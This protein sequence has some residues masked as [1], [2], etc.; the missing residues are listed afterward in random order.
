M[1][2]SWKAA[3]VVPLLLALGACSTPEEAPQDGPP[4]VDARFSGQQLAFGSCD[5]YATTEADKKLFASNDAY[6]CARM[7]VPLDYENPDGATAEIAMLRV[8]ARGESLGPL[9]LNSGGP[10]GTGMNFA[11][12]TATALAASPVTERFDLIGFDPRGVGASTP[13][14]NCFTDEQIATGALNNEFIVTDG[15]ATEAQTRELAE[16]CTQRSGGEQVLAAVGSRDTARDMDVLRAVLGQEKLNFLGQS[17]GTRIGALYAEQFPQHV[18]ALVLDGAV[19]PQLGFA[20]RRL[21]T[22]TAFQATFDAM[23]ADCAT[24][25]GCPLGTDPAGATEAYQKLTRPLVAEPLPVKDGGKLTYNTVVGL[26]TSLLYEPAAWPAITTAM[27][28]LRDGDGNKWIE[29]AEKL[30]STGGT[31]NFEDAI[32]AITC[33]DEERLT[34]ERAVE[35]RQDMR[36]AAPFMDPG[37]SPEGARDSCESWPVEPDPAHPYPAKVEGLPATLTI[38]ITGDTTTPHSGGE[39]LAKTLGGT[40]LTVDGYGHTIAA[41]GQNAC[42]NDA[43]AAYLVDLKTPAADAR[44]TR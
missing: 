43:V 4:P 21:S 18:R 13:Q 30:G 26:T 6:E 36:K 31:A 42:V 25:P 44:C 19:D 3:A 37:T 14:I 29:V 32:Y 40:L 10:G 9:L 11:A 8:P 33:M 16:Q 28:G 24:R 41:T 1:S 35:L 23:A 5:G 22:F 2:R 27:G 7:K 12:M 17:Y 15:A 39:S 34:P 38:S 20:E